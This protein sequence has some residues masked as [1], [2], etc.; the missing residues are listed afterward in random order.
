MKRIAIVGGGPGGLFP[1]RLLSEKLNDRTEITLFEATPRLGGK[2]VIGCFKKSGRE[3]RIS[4][5][6]SLFA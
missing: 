5:C 3:T 6:S 4:T 1:A 2:V